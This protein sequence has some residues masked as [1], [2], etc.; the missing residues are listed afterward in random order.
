MI[1]VY[2]IG[3]RREKYID[4]DELLEHDPFFV[5]V[6][7]VSCKAKDAGPFMQY[8]GGL[9]YKDITGHKLFNGVSVDKMMDEETEVFPVQFIRLSEILYNPRDVY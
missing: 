9:V 3:D 6:S 4:L 7:E 2:K 1:K 8:K 5:A